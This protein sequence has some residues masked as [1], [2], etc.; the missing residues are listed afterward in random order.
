[1]CRKAHGAA[2]GSYGSVP[3]GDFVVTDGA[4][5]I[6]GHQS[7]P[8]VVRSFCSG[9]G[10]PLTWHR[11]E[12]ETADWISFALGTLDTPFAPARQRHV[13]LDSA[14]PWHVAGAASLS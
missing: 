6:R 13:Y 9:C 3:L 11:T 8:G 1:M 10:S 2:F 5:M 14:V 12:G 7:S 4:D